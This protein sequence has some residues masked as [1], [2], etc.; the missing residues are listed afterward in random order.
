MKKM[1]PLMMT[2]AVAFVASYAFAVAN[3]RFNLPGTGGGDAA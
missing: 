2:F 3:N 1:K